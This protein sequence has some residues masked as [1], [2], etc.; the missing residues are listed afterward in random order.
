MLKI[1][2]YRLTNANQLK[3]GLILEIPSISK[4]KFTKSRHII[5]RIQSN[6]NVEFYG[7]LW[8]TI[9]SLVKNNIMVVGEVRRFLKLIPYRYWYSS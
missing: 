2:K 3:P 4:N 8:K 9:D 6:T 1:K 5:K 7:Y